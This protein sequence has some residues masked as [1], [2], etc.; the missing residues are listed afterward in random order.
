MKDL[1]RLPKFLP[2]LCSNFLFSLFFIAFVKFI[3]SYFFF[4]LAL[5]TG[6]VESVFIIVLNIFNL[7]TSSLRN[8]DRI[9]RRY[10]FDCDGDRI[11]LPLRFG[12][13]R[14]LRF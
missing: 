4:S 2:R 11:L 14:I 12:K 13:R 10:L 6:I 1:R 8:D 5:L 7:A 3:S 9:L